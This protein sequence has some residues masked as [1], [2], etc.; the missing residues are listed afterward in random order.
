MSRFLAIL[1]PAEAVSY[2][3]NLALAVSLVCAAGLVAVRVCRQFPAPMRHG[4]LLWALV[5]ILVSP[6]AV[7]LAGKNGAA[8]R[9]L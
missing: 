6:A 5:L 2:L 3:V 8:E 7:W 4:L 1:P 9:Q